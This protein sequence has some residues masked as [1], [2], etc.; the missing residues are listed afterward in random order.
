MPSRSRSP[1][2]SCVLFLSSLVL[3]GCAAGDTRFTVEEPAGFW[4]GLW[5]GLIACVT[6]VLGI[7]YDSVEIY[8]RNNS[9]G[10]YD[11]GFLIGIMSLSGSGHH[12]HRK[13]RCKNDEDANF[14]WSRFPSKGSARAE[15]SW[16]TGTEKE[17]EPDR[18]GG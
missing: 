5:H 4:M 7:F 12:S 14:S 9:G 10:W 16:G 18:Q 15:V 3:A 2:I 1:N 13:W 17:E 11:F 6:L 8:E